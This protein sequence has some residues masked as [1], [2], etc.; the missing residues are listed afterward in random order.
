MDLTWEE[1]FGKGATDPAAH[2]PRH[3]FVARTKSGLSAIYVGSHFKGPVHH[4]GE[5]MATRT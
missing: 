1:P 4:G 2:P 3:S 5:L